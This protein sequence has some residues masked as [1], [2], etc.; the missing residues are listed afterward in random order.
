MK[1]KRWCLNLFS[2][3]SFKLLS[4]EIFNQ[5]SFSSHRSHSW[6][7]KQIRGLRNFV[8]KLSFELKNWIEYNWIFTILRC[9]LCIF[10]IVSKTTNQLTIFSFF[11]YRKYYE[12]IPTKTDNV[13]VI[14]VNFLSLPPFVSFSISSLNT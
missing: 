1:L 9:I 6:S 3:A 10:I 4:F 14:L 12:L 5:P 13:P 7:I 2:M 8:V 11:I